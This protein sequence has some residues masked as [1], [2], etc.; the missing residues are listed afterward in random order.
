MTFEQQNTN[1]RR[2][3]TIIGAAIFVALVVVAGV[4]VGIVLASRNGQQPNAASTSTSSPSA[5]THSAAPAARTTQGA[6]GQ[7]AYETTNTLTAAPATK[8]EPWSATTLATRTGAGPQKNTDGV[9][10]CYSRT[11]EG[12]LYAGFNAAQYCSDSEVLSA[13]LDAVMADGPGRQIAIQQATSAAACDP[14]AQFIQG[15][16]FVS[17]DGSTATFYLDV[18]APSSQIEYGVQM[19]WEDGDWK[20]VSDDQGNSPVASNPLASTSGFTPWG[21]TNG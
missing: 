3:W 4:V 5:G 7:V 9:R 13:A 19:K 11:A 10:T 2:R 8:W 17:Y 14:S 1:P 16:K 21:P 15:Y 18:N 6:C 12:A 20:L